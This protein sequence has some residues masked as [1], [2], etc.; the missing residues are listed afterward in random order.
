M[1]STSM[2]IKQGVLFAALLGL[3]ALLSA[4]NNENLVDNGGFEASKGKAKK[5]GQIDMATG[6]K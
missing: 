2:K 1:K 6:W 5:L 3:P 4:Q